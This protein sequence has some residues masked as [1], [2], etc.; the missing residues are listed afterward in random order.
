M[1]DTRTIAE[2]EREA[3]KR[4]LTREIVN[5]GHDMGDEIDRLIRDARKRI[6]VRYEESKAERSVEIYL[7]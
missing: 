6:I 1:A 7:G 2:I 3:V 5:E 4:F